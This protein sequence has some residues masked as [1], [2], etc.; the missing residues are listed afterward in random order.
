MKQVWHDL[1]FAHW[2]IPL[3]EMRRFV[4]APLEIDCY[5]GSAWVAVTPFHMSGIRA[6]GLPP[7]PGWGAFPELNLRTYVTFNGIP[8]VFFFSLD[9]ANRTAV[10]VARRTYFLPY[11]YSRMKVTLHSNDEVRYSSSRASEPAEFRGRYRPIAGVSIRQQGTLEHFL[12]ERYCLYALRRSGQVLRAH[13]HHLPWPLQD[14][15]LEIECNSVA[16]AAGITL[17][18]NPPLLHFAKRLEVL[19]WWPQLA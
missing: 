18:G 2:P 14:A 9:A 1:L 19:V 7:L 11:F 3:P 15:E 13:I 10:E 5:D 17:P 8:G 12:T 6:R 4:P 16:A